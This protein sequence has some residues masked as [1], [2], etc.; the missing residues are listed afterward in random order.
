MSTSF[1]PGDRVACAGG[2]HAV[3]AELNH[4][5][6]NLC[7]QLPDAVTFE[8]G[9]FATVGSI[10]LHGC[11]RRTPGSANGSRVIGLGLV[12]Q[13]TC[14]L[15]LAAGCEVVGIDLDSALVDRARYSG[16]A[17]AYQ[18]SEIDE[19]NLPPRPRAVT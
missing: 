19:S 16:L 8:A 18:R 6:M 5:P 11:V 14:R 3:H 9:A 12:G 13:I 4:V 7:V 2:G 10:A 17:R 1:G 15:L